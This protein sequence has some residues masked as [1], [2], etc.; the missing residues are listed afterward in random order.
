MPNKVLTILK[1]LAIAYSSICL[2]LWLGQERLIFWPSSAIAKTPT[3]YG[4]EHKNLWL[5]VSTAEGKVE[6][7]HGWW[8][9]A[10]TPEAPAILYLHHNAINIGANIGQAEDFHKL[11]Y[12]VLLADLM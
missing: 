10:K 5:P 7:I 2:L 12:S 8:I 6:R 4:L 11:G 1:R 3:A 9:P